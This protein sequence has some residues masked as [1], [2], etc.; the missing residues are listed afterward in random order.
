MKSRKGFTLMEMI[1]VIA[2]IV[3]LSAVT[4]A[5]VSQYIQKSNELRAGVDAHSAMVDQQQ[6]VVDNY[7][8][9][10]RAKL[11]SSQT[12]N[13]SQQANDNTPGGNNN[14]NNGGNS[15]PTP[16]PTP[17]PSA[18]P[19]PSPTPSPTPA[20]PPPPAGNDNP[21]GAASTYDTNEINTWNG[22]KTGNGQLGVTNTSGKNLEAGKYS[23]TVT[24]ANNVTVGG[25]VKVVSGNGTKTVTFEPIYNETLTN[26]SRV[27]FYITLDS[28]DGNAINIT[29]V[30]VNEK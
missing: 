17:A 4:F 10:T 14:P 11:E 27:K 7:L 6:A 28:K 25:N 1:C 21:G 19:T 23:I 15:Q 5:S 9:T 18:T 13:T 29:G 8:T 12:A 3:F 20:P 2:I 24:F 30:T 16:T 22:G 26:N